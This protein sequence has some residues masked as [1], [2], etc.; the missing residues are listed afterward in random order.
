MLFECRFIIAVS[1]PAFFDRPC[2]AVS[3]KPPPVHLSAMQAHILLFVA[4][5]H[6]GPWR[7][8]N[9]IDFR[10]LVLRSCPITGCDP[11]RVYAR[12]THVPG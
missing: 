11:S 3:S 10:V 9:E 12:Y 4:C 2:R 8:G 6:A 1:L 7:A 5:L